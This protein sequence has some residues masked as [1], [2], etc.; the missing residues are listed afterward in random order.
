MCAGASGPAAA[1]TAWLG[2]HC[3]VCPTGAAGLGVH[4]GRSLRCL[5]AC[6]WS[7]TGVECCAEPSRDLYAVLQPE[8]RRS[9]M[10]VAVDS[11]AAFMVGVGPQSLQQV[12]RTCATAALA[13][14]L[15]NSQS[16]SACYIAQQRV[17]SIPGRWAIAASQRLQAQQHDPPITTIHV[18]CAPLGGGP[19]LAAHC[20][21][22][23]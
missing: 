12:T 8:S 22:L 17:C 18:R 13:S 16:V 21:L 7:W 6:C 5:W 23:P 3:C 2:A 11:I 14:S 19:W 10:S 15:L 9:G 20:W 1:P 4:M